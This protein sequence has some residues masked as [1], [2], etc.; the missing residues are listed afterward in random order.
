MPAH[1][2]PRPIC[3]RQRILQRRKYSARHG[4]RNIAEHGAAE[5]AEAGDIAQQPAWRKPALNDC[6]CF[7]A[8]VEITETPRK[9]LK[10]PLR[11][12]LDKARLQRCSRN[13][14]KSH[15]RKAVRDGVGQ[16]GTPGPAL[17]KQITPI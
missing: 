14:L 9:G 7:L 13:I 10:E 5:L 1:V 2:E 17:L 12:V 6:A 3:F 16:Y 8:A 15:G 11:R 4:G